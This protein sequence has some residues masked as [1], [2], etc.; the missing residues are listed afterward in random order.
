MYNEINN[1]LLSDRKGEAEVSKWA[2]RIP[3]HFRV[4]LRTSESSFYKK[5]GI[6]SVIVRY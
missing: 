3:P 6:L 4:K 5:H 2:V 1:N